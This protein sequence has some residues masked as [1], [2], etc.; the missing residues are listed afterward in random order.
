MKS[1]PKQGWEGEASEQ[2]PEKRVL[3]RQELEK[4]YH[5]CNTNPQQFYEEYN[6]PIYP[7]T[8]PGEKEPG[9]E[10]QAGGAADTGIQQ[11]FIQDILERGFDY[12]AEGTFDMA[13]HTKADKE[14]ATRQEQQTFFDTIKGIFP[15]I[16]KKK[17]KK[18][19]YRKKRILSL[20]RDTK[21]RSIIKECKEY[22]M[23]KI[24][25]TFLSE[26]KK[27]QHISISIYRKLAEIIENRAHETFEYSSII[28]DIDM[29]R[30][31]ECLADPYNRLT[32]EYL[33]YSTEHKKTLKVIIGLD[34]SGSTSYPITMGDD[35]SETILDIEKHFALIF[36][37]ALGMLTDM[38]D[39][40]GFNSFTSTNIY[41]AVPV[42]ALT[43]FVSDNSNRDG[44]FI[45]Y[46]NYIFS[47]SSS[48]L[49]YFFL[50]S[51]GMPNA[52]NYEGKYALDDTL[53]AMRESREQNIRLIYFNIDTELREYFGFFKNEA[54]YAEYFSNPHQLLEAI[55]ELVM[56]IA[57]EVV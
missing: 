14:G 20:N 21:T 5:Q 52:I 48:D 30:L 18:R 17:K 31:I 23:N 15:G 3:S 41:H 25:R 13:R 16:K 46:I 28:G 19:T 36:A 26:N 6:I 47:E 9:K 56:S 57:Q 11:S 35:K 44:D 1:G 55:P 4:L 2:A 34:I 39:V 53:I 27:Y 43:G 49:N 24:S 40:Y 7:E 50:I 45:R 12:E 10:K 42:E 29:D 38:I 54:L 8:F 33:E 22:E 32:T 51:D 37:D